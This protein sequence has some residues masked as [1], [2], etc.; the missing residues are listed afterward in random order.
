MSR[1]EQIK[2]G[3]LLDI[4]KWNRGLE[5]PMT[6]RLLLQMA[7]NQNLPITAHELREHLEYLALKEYVTIL[8]RQQMPGYRVS[9][10]RG[11]ERPDHIVTAKL[12]AKAFDLLEG[13]I[14][15]PGVIV[16]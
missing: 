11:D 9:D 14:K 12:T 10:L 6:F 15:D 5:I 13:T 1:N 3:T 16:L 8:R 2:R 4:L 7:H